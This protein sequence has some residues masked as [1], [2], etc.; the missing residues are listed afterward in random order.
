MSEEIGSIV[1]GV[2]AGTV[3]ENVR[4]KLQEVQ[5]K[6]KVFG[7]SWFEEVLVCWSYLGVHSG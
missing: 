7:E 1:A 4:P 5:E 2:P 3:G 6:L